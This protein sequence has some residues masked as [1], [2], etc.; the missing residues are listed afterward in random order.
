MTLAI[1]FK[2]IAK[3]LQ[4]DNDS[5]QDLDDAINDKDQIYDVMSGKSDFVCGMAT[6]ILSIMRLNLAAAVAEFAL[7]SNFGMSKDEIKFLMKTIRL[8]NVGLVFMNK[9]ELIKGA[10]LGMIEGDKLSFDLDDFNIAGRII[11]WWED[12][13]QFDSGESAEGVHGEMLSMNK[14]LVYFH[15][16]KKN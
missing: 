2:S 15:E 10:R 16:L 4:P 3:K 6:V 5:L 12:D 14:K 11:V 13:H 9:Y 1:E 8:N 7:F